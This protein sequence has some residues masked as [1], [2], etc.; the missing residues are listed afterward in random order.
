MIMVCGLTFSKKEEDALVLTCILY[1]RQYTPLTRKG[2]IDLASTFARKPEGKKNSW[3]FADGFVK[4][5]HE[6]LVVKEEEVTSSKRSLYT[7]LQYTEDFI[8]L[9]NTLRGG[10]TLNK[11]NIEILDESVFDDGSRIPLSL[12]NGETLLAET[13]MH[14]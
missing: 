9:I 6:D 14:S 3:N 8:D 7:L 2:F 13:S 4:Q 11:N 12:M 1:A 5:R 10:N